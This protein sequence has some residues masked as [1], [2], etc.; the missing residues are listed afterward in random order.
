MSTII[1]LVYGLLIG[2]SADNYDDFFEKVL[3]QDDFRPETILTD[4]EAGTIKSVKGIL[5]NATHKGKNIY[6]SITLIIVLLGCLFHFGQCVWRQVQSKGLAT[7]YQEDEIFRLNVKRLI[8]LAF[9]PLANVATGFD[10]VTGEFDDDADDLLDYFEKTWIGE[11]KRRGKKFIINFL[12]S[13]LFLKGI[14]RK[15]PQF[16]HTLWNIYDRVVADLPRSNNSVEGWHSAF[17]TRVAIAHPTIKKLADKIRRE[18][19]KFEIDIAQLLQGHPP[20]P[21]KACYQKLDERIARVVSNYNP[22]QI[23]EYLKNI[24]ANVSL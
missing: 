6:Y 5:P 9:L 11:P 15:K 22:L 3:E 10:L 16:E 20:K 18:Q 4:F 17:A 1:P 23:L 13:H 7:K 21:K 12:T 8:A 19:S 2:K 24:A 14:G